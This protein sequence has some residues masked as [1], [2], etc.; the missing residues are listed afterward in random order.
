MIY[1]IESNLTTWSSARVVDDYESGHIKVFK[2]LRRTEAD[3]NVDLIDVEE[4]VMIIN[5]QG[6]TPMETDDGEL[7]KAHEQH[8]V[9]EQEHSTELD[10][11]ISAQSAEDID[12]SIKTKVDIALFCLQQHPDWAS[13]TI[14]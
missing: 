11:K 10:N 14:Y 1:L 13:F 4:N 9:L 6:L 7:L 3:S 8:E 5:L 2:N 12:Q